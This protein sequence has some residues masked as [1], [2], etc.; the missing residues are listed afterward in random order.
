MYDRH[1]GGM[2]RQWDGWEGLWSTLGS[3]GDD[4]MIMHLRAGMARP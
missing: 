1:T 3:T 2:D 4:E